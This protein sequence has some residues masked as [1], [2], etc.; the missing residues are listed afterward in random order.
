[1]R[2][3]ETLVRLPLVGIV[4]QR[5]YAFWRENIAIANVTHVLLGV[6]LVLLFFGKSVVGL[7]LLVIVVTV[8]IVAF[9]VSGK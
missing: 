1:M 5:S 7:A 3:D 8:H 2:F 4:F 6:G 9:I